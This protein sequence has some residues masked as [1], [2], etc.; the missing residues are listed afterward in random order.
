MI[1]A[2]AAGLLVGGYFWTE[3]RD[4]EADWS[5]AD[6]RGRTQPADTSEARR[7][8]DATPVETEDADVDQEF[9]DVA[10]YA[11]WELTFYGRD[12]T[13]HS[14]R[15]Q[16]HGSRGELIVAFFDPF[17]QVVLV[18]QAV[19]YHCDEDY[20]FYEGSDPADANTHRPMPEYVPDR[21]YVSEDRYGDLQLDEVCD[22]YGDHCSDV[23]ATF[24]GS[25]R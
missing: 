21:I 15:L 11:S 22:T 14:G 2:L 6:D 25:S 3:H 8:Q 19:S 7:E 16:M 18:R 13:P 4:Q 5:P 24:L 17:Q 1:V 23:T 12:G 20:C 9:S 10:R